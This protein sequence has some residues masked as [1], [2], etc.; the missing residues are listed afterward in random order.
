MVVSSGSCP[1]KDGWLG[2]PSSA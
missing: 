1:S 2:F